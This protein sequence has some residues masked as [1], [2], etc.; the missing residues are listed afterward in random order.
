VLSF[1]AL[2][3]SPN[4]SLDFSWFVPSLL[5]DMDLPDIVAGLA[6]RSCWIRNSVDPDGKALD[7]SAAIRRF[8]EASSSGRQASP[9]NIHFIAEDAADP[10]TTYLDW[11]RST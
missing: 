5:R 3:E 11:L 10:Q 6:P 1:A 9:D 7:K 8:L 2:V 4:Y